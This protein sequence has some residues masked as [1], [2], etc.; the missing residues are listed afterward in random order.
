M[1]EWAWVNVVTLQLIGMYCNSMFPC[2]ND[3]GNVFISIN[4]AQGERPNGQLGSCPSIG[5]W[6][7]KAWKSLEMSRC[8]NNNYSC[9]LF[10]Y[11]KH[12][13][14]PKGRE[15]EK[16]KAPTPNIVLRSCANGVGKSCTKEKYAMV[17]FFLFT[18]DVVHLCPL[19]KKEKYPQH[20]IYLFIN[21]LIF[22]MNIIHLCPQKKKKKVHTG[23]RE[24]KIGLERKSP[25]RLMKLKT[26]PDGN[27]CQF[28][29]QP[30]SIVLLP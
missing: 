28:E 24:K 27:C 22:S 8:Y 15:R 21:Y 20:W 7:K 12:T 14:I 30:I 2:I 17:G 9:Y 18:M 23:R 5:P 13:K 11:K 6:R 25:C 16:K 29:K 4:G 1:I 26:K 19:P 10:S 3:V